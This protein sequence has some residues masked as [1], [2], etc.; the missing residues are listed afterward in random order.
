M[1]HSPSSAG[2]GQSSVGSRLVQTVLEI[3]P[4]RNRIG[5]VVG[6]SVPPGRTALDE[7]G[8]GAAYGVRHVL[9]SVYRVIYLVFVAVILQAEQ[10]VEQDLLLEHLDPTIG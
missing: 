9:A 5:L 7:R 1:S 3:R 8:V 6:R 4:Q 10:F 2:V